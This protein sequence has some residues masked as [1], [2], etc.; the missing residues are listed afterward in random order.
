MTKEGGI[1]TAKGFLF[2]LSRIA[3]VI[4][5]IAL[6]IVAFYAAMNT[7][8]IRMVAKDAFTQR[9]TAVLMDDEDGTNKELLSRFFTEYYLSADSL[10]HGSAYDDFT[11]T[12]YYQRTDVDGTIVWPWQDH[13]TINVD[14]LVTDIAGTPI[15]QDEAAAQEGLEITQ[16]PPEWQNGTYAVTLV[17]EDNTWKIDGIK[18]VKA[19]E[20]TV[21]TSPSAAVASPS[22]SASQAADE[23]EDGETAQQE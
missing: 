15:V 19:V 13:A 4:V 9:A 21:T 7:M 12:N 23:P 8:N 22:A 2:V 20:P 3:I 16:K 17:K 6:V 14:D 10:L 11:I 18:F 1:K 5:V